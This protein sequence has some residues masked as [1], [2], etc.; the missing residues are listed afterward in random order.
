MSLSKA[1]PSLLITIGLFHHAHA[2][3][4]VHPVF[5]RGT[6]GTITPPVLYGNED[7]SWQKN[8]YILQTTRLV[9]LICFAVLVHVLWLRR[10]SSRSQVHIPVGDFPCKLVPRLLALVLIHQSR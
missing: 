10:H 7:K 2:R 8:V 3:P 1:Y 9:L 5:V 6:N 4:S